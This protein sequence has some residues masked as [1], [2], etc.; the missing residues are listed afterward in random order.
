MGQ[1]E[2]L[3]LFTGAV[4]W[5]LVMLSLVLTASVMYPDIS[6]EAIL[7]VLGGGTL[8]AVAGYVGASALRKVRREPAPSADYDAPAYSKE[9]RDTWRM[10]PLKELPLPVLTR[11]SRIWMGVL[12]GYLVVA[13]G[14]VIFKVVE[15]ALMR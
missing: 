14:L 7:G 10:P 5:V 13:V 6:G 3:N 1:L 9:A 8:L 11:S 12:R 15:M 4:I 2:R